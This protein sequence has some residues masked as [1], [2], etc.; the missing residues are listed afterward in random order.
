MLVD[1]VH[2]TAADGL[3]LDGV[4]HSAAKTQTENA[5]CDAIVCIHGTGSN[6]YSSGIFQ[7]LTPGWLERGMQVVWANTRGH[8]GLTTAYTDKGRRRLGAA[9]E[10][11]KESP[12]DLRAWADFLV[13]R[14]ATRIVY[15]GH[16]AGAVKAIY[17]QAVQPH[18]AV[19]GVAA[20]SPPRL[21]HS[22]FS[23]SAKR[24]EF[25]D[26]FRRA[27]M[28]VA[29]GEAKALME[30]TFPMPYV[31][32]AGGYLE[33]Y[34]PAEQYNI[35]KL[36]PQVRCPTL[37]TYGSVEVE[38]EVAFQG[39]PDAVM[40]LSPTGERVRTAVIDGA[41][42]IYTGRTEQLGRVVENWLWP[43]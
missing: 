8:D 16:S 18:S 2:I 13:E 24:R 25:L 31:V 7:K 37:V 19:V 26:T 42:H 32:S 11:F 12:L 9:Y 33:K 36:L 5:R 29:A 41:D 30:V 35:L 43:T 4:L 3:R 17:S 34:G 20:V 38:R 39:L 28:L 15:F 10:Q 1:L 14:G 23:Q 6:F 27:E 21:S 40:Q 22:F